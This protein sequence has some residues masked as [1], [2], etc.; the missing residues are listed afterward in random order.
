MQHHVNKCYSSK[1]EALKAI[2][3]GH[4]KVVF[5][6]FVTQSFVIQAIQLNF[7][8]GQARLFNEQ[9]LGLLSVP[10]HWCCF[11]NSARHP[12]SSSRRH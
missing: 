11:F 10:L 1:C 6:Y 4:H 2:L 3:A 7:T 8:V 9:F 12:A 5:I